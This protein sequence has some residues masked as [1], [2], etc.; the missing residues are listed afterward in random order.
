MLYSTNSMHKFKTNFASRRNIKLS[1][2]RSFKDTLYDLTESHKDKLSWRRPVRMKA[3]SNM[4]QVKND[5][6]LLFYTRRNRR[7]SKLSSTIP[8]VR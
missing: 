8:M 2:R 4:Y 3:L 1:M 7:K 5:K 6:R